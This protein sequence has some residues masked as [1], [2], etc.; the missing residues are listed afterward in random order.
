MQ[1]LMRLVGRLPRPVRKTLRAVVGGDG[2]RD[3]WTHALWAWHHARGNRRVDNIAVRLAPLIARRGGIEGR[4]CLDFGAGHVLS[5]A[6][7]M[8]LAGAR[9][10]VACDYFP[11]QRTA[12][13]ERAYRTCDRETLRAALRPVA[14]IETVDSRLAQLDSL[15]PF[16]LEALARLGVTY[17][18]PVDF[19]ATPPYACEFDFIHS[20]AVLEHI[21]LVAVAPILD[22]LY[23]ALAPGGEMVHMIHLEDHLDYHTEPFAF[24]AADSGWTP[25][26]A[27]SRGNRLRASDWLGRLAA[28]P[29]ARTEVVWSNVRRD[30]PLPQ[31]LGPAFAG[32]AEADLRTG[33]LLVSTRRPDCL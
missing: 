2:H 28:L 8:W 30:C 26:D 7:V 14:P 1:T 27:D 6:L 16:T 29:N 17:A 15:R 31:N 12:F 21:P 13:T 11:I 18:A 5:E 33:A 25:A 22:N 4:S 19:A 32:Y 24:L 3:H 23:T 10:V 9:R 20:M